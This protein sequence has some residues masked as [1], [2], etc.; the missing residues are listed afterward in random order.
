M[1]RLTEIY[2][3]DRKILKCEYIRYSPAK[4]STKNT[5][6]SQTYIDILRED[7]VISLLNSYLD[8]HF[9]VIKKTDKARYANSNDIRLLYLGT[10]A[11]FSN[12]ILTTSS[13]KRLEDKSHA[14]I[15]SLMYKLLT[16]AKEADGLSMGFDRGRGRIREG[17]P[18]KISLKVNTMLELRSKMFLVLP[19]IMKKLHTA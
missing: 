6:N 16:N 9:E 11:L 17:W 8:L 15:V 5:P 18:I 4:A 12:F 13:G 3:F 10:I 14:H 7:S 2:E 19:K 1:F